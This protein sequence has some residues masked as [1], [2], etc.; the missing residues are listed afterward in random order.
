M[1]KNVY[2]F[3]FLA[4]SLLISCDDNNDNKNDQSLDSITITSDQNTLN[5]RLD[6]TNSGVIA[7]ENGS[8][9]GKS[10]ENTVTSFP[11]DRKSVV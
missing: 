6:Y 9:T 10:A 3:S 4:L 2:L 7:I 1:K 8:L 11:L 5:Q